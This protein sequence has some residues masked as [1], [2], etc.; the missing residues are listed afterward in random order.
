[1]S[2]VGFYFC[3]KNFSILKTSIQGKLL[4]DT[5]EVAHLWTAYLTAY[6]LG[7]FLSSYLG[8]RMSMRVLVLGGMALTLICNFALGFSYLM[9]PAGY[10]PMMAL[11]VINGFAQATGWP[12]NVGIVGNWVDRKERGRVFAIWATCYQLGSSFAKMFA[13]FML[14]F[15]GAVWSFWGASVVMIGV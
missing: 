7:Q 6:M 10:W 9:G 12:G 2:Y 15:L 1:M 4:I 3:R 8:R 14:G 5:S 11:M 13:S